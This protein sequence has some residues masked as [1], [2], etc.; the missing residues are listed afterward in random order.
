MQVQSGYWTKAS[1]YLFAGISLVL[2]GYWI[3]RWRQGLAPYATDGGADL[4]GFIRWLLGYVFLLAVI[5]GAAWLNH[6]LLYRKLVSRQTLLH[7]AYFSWL[8]ILWWILFELFQNLNAYA[9]EVIIE[10]WF[11]S[12][13]CTLLIAVLTLAIDQPEIRRKRSELEQDKMEAEL[14]NL[15][16]QLHPHFLFNTLNTI[17]S[18]ALQQDQEELATLIAE[19]SGLLRFSFK[20]AKQTRV[21]LHEEVDFLRRYIH[22]QQARL[23]PTQQQAVQINVMDEVPSYWL[24]PLLLIPFVE[25]AFVHGIFDGPDFFL[26]I[27]LSVQGDHLRLQIANGLPAKQRLGGSGTGISNTRQRLERLYQNNYLL[28]EE[29][30]P[31]IYRMQLKFP[32]SLSA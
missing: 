10:N 5:L 28:E 19:L 12:L 23:T 18:E 1:R 7:W 29:Q 15:R 4:A 16:A 24:P 13:L 21:T 2:L 32:L 30:T 14:H 27:E 25:N 31:D 22:L 11:V 8:L 17:Y 26:H 20:H 6:R 3:Y 9:T